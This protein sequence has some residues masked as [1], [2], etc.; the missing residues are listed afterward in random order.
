[1]S[2][3][4]GAGLSAPP[5][6]GCPCPAARAPLMPPFDHDIQRHTQDT[7]GRDTWWEDRNK[8]SFARQLKPGFVVRDGAGAL[9]EGWVRPVAKPEGAGINGLQRS[10]PIKDTVED[11][12]II[13]MNDFVVPFGFSQGKEAIIR[14]GRLYGDTLRQM[15]VQVDGEEL[16]IHIDGEEGPITGVGYDGKM[17]H[18]PNDRGIY[19]LGPNRRPL[20]WAEMT[21]SERIKVI[22]MLARQQKEMKVQGLA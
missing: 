13:E 14:A 16:E 7:R 3:S 11:G 12:T 9:G 8:K 21:S 10:K 15:K 18:G 4:R 2:G 5:T 20:E 1:M 22:I 19:S 6:R 17:L